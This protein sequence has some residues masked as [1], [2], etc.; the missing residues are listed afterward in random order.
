MP[1]GRRVVRAIVIVV[2]DLVM[3]EKLQ[4]HTGAV[5]RDAQLLALATHPTVI[6]VTDLVMEKL[7]VH[8]GAV[9]RDAQLLALATH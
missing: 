7:Q 9:A 1:E 4:V 2:T 8:T 3:E 5:A 6:V